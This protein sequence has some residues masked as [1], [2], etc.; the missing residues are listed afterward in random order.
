[1]ATGLEARKLD[2]REQVH[3]LVREEVDLFGVL[4]VLAGRG[5]VGEAFEVGGHDLVLAFQVVEERVLVPF[6]V[7]EAR[8][9]RR[10]RRCRLGMRA[11]REHGLREFGIE[12]GGVLPELDVRC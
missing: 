10:R 9:R 8:I 12:R 11:R 3:Q 6:L 4:L 5:L 2:G 1:M 7:G